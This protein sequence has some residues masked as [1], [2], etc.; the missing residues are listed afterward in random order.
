[1]KR[2]IAL[3]ASV[4][5]AILA[6]AA[7]KDIT[8]TA[9]PAKDSVSA[10]DKLFKEKHQSAKGMFTLHKIKEKVYFEIPVAMMGKEMLIASTVTKTSDNGNGIVGA[11]PDPIHV[12]FSYNGDNV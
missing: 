8:K 9:T 11:K 2:F 6:V 5:L 12:A 4:L 1:M 10:Y 3:S 7:P